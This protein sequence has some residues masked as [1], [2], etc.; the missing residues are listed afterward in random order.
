MM[1]HRFTLA[2]LAVVLLSNAV[3]TFGA[4]LPPDDTYVQVKD[5]HLSLA[6]ERVRYWGFIGAPWGRPDP[7]LSGEERREAIAKTRAD[8]ELSV[9]RIHD[10]GFN[11]LRSWHLISTEP[12]TKGDGSEADCLAYYFDCLD[13]K[14]I[15]V[16]QGMVNQHDVRFTP[17]DVGII[18]EPATAPGWKA[19]VAEWTVARKGEAPGGWSIARVWDKRIDALALAHM[20][21]KADFRNLYKDGL[22]LADDPQM[23]VWELTNEESWYGVMFGGG[24]WRELPAFFRNELLDQWCA[25]L[26]KKYGSEEKLLAAWCFLVPGE[27][28]AQKSIMLLPL[29]SPST[30]A[31]AAND[32]N[33]EALAKLTAVKKA[34]AQEDFTRKRGEDVVEFLTHLY[35][36]HK[37]RTADA[38]KT[39]G[40]GCK[41]SPCIW[42][43]G[44]PYQIQNAYMHQFSDASVSDTYL[45]GMAHDPTYKRWPFYSGLEAPPRMAW[46]VPWVEQARQKGKPFFCYEIQIDCR[47]KYRAEFPLRVAALAAIQDWDIVNWHTYDSGIDSSKPDPF[48]SQLHVWHDYFGYGQDEV[49]LSAMKA[50]AETFKHSLLAP[51]PKPTTFIFGRKSLYDPASMNY[52]KSY[53]EMGRR[54]FPTCYRYGVQVL[55]DPLREDDAIEGPSYQEDILGA[56]PVRP[57]VQIEY[58]WSQGHLTFDAPGVIGYTGFYGQ[59]K[60]PVTFASGASFSAVTVVNP[61]GIAYPVTPEEGYVAIMVASQDGKPLAQTKRALVSA[62]S[63]SF[64]SGYHLDL[65]KSTQGNHGDGPKHVPPQEWFG[66]YAANSGKSPVLVARVGVT[67]TCKDIDGMGYTLRDWKMKNIGQG[68]IKNGVLTVP[69]DEPIFIIELRR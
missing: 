60:G 54:F 29:G 48:G 6:R 4:E 14:G 18:D 26:Q 49:Q 67:I 1:R 7:K 32:T 24:Q 19:A 36:A 17:N 62:V 44:S 63:T 12:Y 69:A 56:N 59:R 16:W 25:F 2:L 47:T 65:T 23:V 34:Y 41:L 31:L 55:I 39:W 64:N 9:E 43:T 68:L 11:L 28:L 27:S 33:P 8:I 46:N 30:S 53:G 40:K 3:Q 20:Q 58:D 10:L 57:N 50:C 22:R 45:K 52:G 61:P 51:A 5:G 66:A 15:K 37:Q 13:R 21:K 38:L 42:E 35:I